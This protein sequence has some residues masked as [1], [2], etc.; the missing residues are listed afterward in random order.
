[1]IMSDYNYRQI[2]EILF[3]WGQ[4]SVL[5]YLKEQDQ[6]QITRNDQ[7]TLI[8]D[9]TFDFCL[10][11]LI[12]SNPIFAPYQN[13]SFEAMS[14]DSKRAQETG[15]PELVYFFYDESRMSKKEVVCEVSKGVRYCSDYKP[16]VLKDTYLRKRGIINLGK[17]EYYKVIHPSDIK[18]IEESISCKDYVCI[19]TFAQ[20][21]VL[22]S[23][24]FTI[25][26]LPE[27]FF[28]SRI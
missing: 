2:K 9:F 5:K 19:D 8:I 22:N 13:V 3:K 15:K 6:M 26:V 20:Y 27:V 17:D 1:M 7:E 10:A 11:Q 18:K 21:L 28:C 23:G 14:L 12:V 4:E 16:D 25:R 24:N